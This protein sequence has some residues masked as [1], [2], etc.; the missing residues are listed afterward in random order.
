MRGVR[1]L[2]WQSFVSVWTG[3]ALWSRPLDDVSAQWVVSELL[4]RPE[5]PEQV[6]GDY[7]RGD[8]PQQWAQERVERK[9]QAQPEVEH[10]DRQQKQ[11]GVGGDPD[12]LGDHCNDFTS[13][14]EGDGSPQTPALAL[15]PGASRGNDCG[16]RPPGR[17]KA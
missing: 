8:K 9:S 12:S 5:N 10:D 14:R 11:Q 4:A 13:S 2:P 16:M 15:P 17:L 1:G 3:D 7:G 6:Q